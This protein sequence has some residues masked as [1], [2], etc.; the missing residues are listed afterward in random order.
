M[1]TLVI[2]IIKIKIIV[3]SPKICLLLCLGCLGLK[4]FKWS[5][6]VLMG[7]PTGTCLATCSRGISVPGH[8]VF[9]RTQ[10]RLPRAVVDSVLPLFELGG[11]DTTFLLFL[12]L[13]TN[14]GMYQVSLS[15]LPGSLCLLL[16][17]L[18]Y[19]GH[20]TST[21]FGC[22]LLTNIY[23]VSHEVL[24]VA[25]LVSV[26]QV[27]VQQCPEDEMYTQLFEPGK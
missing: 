13:E 20:G 17:C 12:G 26:G 25:C 18:F 19:D 8:E 24:V 6:P 5:L 21:M 1:N 22:Q 10:S 16:L 15:H 27:G 2:I 4:E 7:G 23:D 14:P 3:N 11:A 9:T